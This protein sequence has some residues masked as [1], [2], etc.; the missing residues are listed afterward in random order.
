MKVGKYW[1][2][3]FEDV[4]VYKEKVKVEQKVLLIEMM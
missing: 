4:V 2:V 1:R 3:M